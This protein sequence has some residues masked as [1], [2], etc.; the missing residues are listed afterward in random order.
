MKWRKDIGIEVYF[1]FFFIFLWDGRVYT[2]LER[3]REKVIEES[4][5]QSC[6]QKEIT[7][8][9]LLQRE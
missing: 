8:G 4:D 2:G 5:G 9:K 1:S 6:R 7:G 3:V